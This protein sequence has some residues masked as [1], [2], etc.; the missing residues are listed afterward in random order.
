MVVELINTGTE[1][2]LGRVL[3]THQHWLCRQLADLGYVVSRQ[4]AVPDTGAEIQQAVREA[5]GRADLVLTTGGLGPT[6]DD[7]TRDLIAQMLGRPLRE[8]AAVL[9]H[10]RQFFT[11]RKRPMP[12]RTSVQALVPEG[13]I[14]LPNPHG[15]APGLAMEV[16][17][18]LLRSNGAGT[19]LVMLPGPPR[20]LRPMFT[21][22]VVPLLRRVLPV[23]S[24]FV[25]RTL[26]TTGIGES[27]V[28]Q[29]IAKPLQWLV[30]AGLDLGYC[31][32]PGQVDVRLA[33]QGERAA[34]QVEEAEAI[35]R[36]LLGSRIYGMEDD[37][38]ERVIV[39]LFTERQ[40]SLALAES[41]TGGFIANRI[42]NVPGASAVLLAG[43][44]TYSNA[45]K[46]R[47]LGVR[48]ETLARHGAVSEA[49]AREMAEGARR[50]AGADYALAVTGIAGPTGGTAEKPVGTV[51]I[52]LAGP[53]G[54]VIERNLN[55]YD[56]DT[57]KQVTT[58]QGLDLIRRTVLAA[59]TDLR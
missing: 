5:L 52:G 17:P 23:P 2:M 35:V 28:Q 22:A 13:A 31:S 18:N 49:T 45:A 1:L 16:H 8:D 27:V 20:E 46:E 4:V 25:C 42:T 59:A 30:E 24:L 58:Q 10:I 40:A 41:C 12:E 9:G 33:A 50:E 3:N 19:W 39:R 55:P 57:F 38:L 53:A 6:S 32:R 44:V 34:S 47:F 11:A 21:E 7:I 29:R 26:R 37:E 43:L 54:T 48:A 51:F 15:T 14:V 56:R 36:E